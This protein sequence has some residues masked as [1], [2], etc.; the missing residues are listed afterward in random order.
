MSLFSRK[1]SASEL[2]RLRNEEQRAAE[3][4]RDNAAKV[5]AT[6]EPIYG[7]GVHGWEH[8]AATFQE[9]ADGYQQQLDSKRS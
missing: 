6:G 7:I 4:C 1:P 3:A 5:A 2:T 9:A 8:R